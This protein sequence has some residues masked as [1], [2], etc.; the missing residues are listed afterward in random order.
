MISYRVSSRGSRGDDLDLVSRLYKTLQA[1]ISSVNFDTWFRNTP[2]HYQPPCLFIFTTR[3][4][5]RKAWL[6]NEY[7][8]VIARAARTVCDFEPQFLFEIQGQPPEESRSSASP[9]PK[10]LLGSAERNRAPR[11][12]TAVTQ[13][14]NR[15]YTFESFVSGKGSEVAH[16]AA[17]AVSEQP[18]S[19]YNPLYIYGGTGVGKTHLLQAIYHH[20]EKNSQ[21]HL[22]YVTAETFAN[23][24]SHA[25]ETRELDGFR[26]SY[27]KTDVLLV[28]DIHFLPAKSRAQDEFFHTFRAL[29]SENHQV[30]IADQSP[31][32]ELR[33]LN[34][35]LA[36]CFQGGL[37]TIL[38]PPDLNTRL[39]ILVRK[40]LNRGYELPP[41][42]GRFLAEQVP[43]N[44]RELEGAL[45]HLIGL[46]SLHRSP[47]SLEMAESALKETQSE[48]KPPSEVINV[49]FIL[50]TI[51]EYYGVKQK[52][53]LSSSK[54]RSL[55]YARHV[56]MYLARELTP[57]SLVQ[58]GLRFGGKDHSTVLYAQSRISKQLKKNP[59]VRV[60][61]Q[62]LRCR[63]GASPTSSSIRDEPRQ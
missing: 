35:K 59:Q 37:V 39:I 61:L 49:D 12:R 15:H 22:A 1:E 3:N 60:D 11:S 57:L 50:R 21:L 19:S 33:G 44:L 20:L 54:V 10:R 16:A 52:E 48:G 31:P 26:H 17:L 9:D 6:S 30:V 56:G 29:L 34:D 53:L 51:G 28:D 23:Q 38:T 14:T 62:V 32:M 46:A 5:F 2:C 58:I 43:N 55:V 47:L 18:G 7:L 36:S 41:E 4:K 45:N 24:Y 42:T 8:E 13:R 25:V 27:R 40:A 63:L